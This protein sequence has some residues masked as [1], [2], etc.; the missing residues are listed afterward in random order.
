[1]HR[2]LVPGSGGAGR[3]RGGLGQEIRIL[4]TSPTPTAVFL[5]AE[6]TRVPARGIA[7]GEAGATGAVEINGVPVDPKVQHL[8]RPGD[9][10][11]LRTPGG[12]G[13]GPH[14]ERDPGAAARDRTLG[15]T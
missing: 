10:V 4:N 1:M 7:G 5:S 14:G 11:T 13:H 8:L 12:G 3:H 9:V 15:Y 2:A 6:R